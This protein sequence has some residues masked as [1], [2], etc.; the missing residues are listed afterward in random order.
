MPNLESW[1]ADL[2]G[3]SAPGPLQ[4][5]KAL[6]QKKAVLRKTDVPLAGEGDIF[7]RRRKGIDEILEQA[8]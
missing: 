1:S 7:E 8:R 5:A 4:L 3:L 6:R 2:R